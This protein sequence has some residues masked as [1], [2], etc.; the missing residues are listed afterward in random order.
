MSVMPTYVAFLRAINLG[1]KRKVPMAELR[2]CL[3]DAGY[4]DVE[5]HIQTGNVRL[6]T[7]AR[8]V[9]KVEEELEHLLGR[10]FGFEIPAI[11]F[12]P[13]QL[14]E[15]YDDALAFAPPGVKGEMR[16]VSLFKRGEAP[17]GEDAAAIDAWDAPGEAGVV[18]GRAVHIWIDGT[19]Q[20]SRILT[21]FKKPL[22]PGTNRNTKVLVA[23]TEKWA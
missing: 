16:Y 15:V 19:S 23:V 14:R 13:E 21:E 8:S 17:T 12:T 3:T 9:A 11:V 6:R 10:R 5:T 22:W 20:A 7:P 1:A 4:D 2:T 18:K